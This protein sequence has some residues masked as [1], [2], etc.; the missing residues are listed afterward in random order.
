MQAAS[1][2]TL[3]RL[4][5][6]E[7]LARRF[8]EFAARMPQA[9]AVASQHRHMTYA[10]LNAHSN[11]LSLLL[12]EI[13]VAPE[14]R[15]AVLFDPSPEMAIAL[16]G[17]IKSGGAYVPLDPNW[18][19]SRI[20]A[21]LNDAAATALVTQTEFDGRCTAR[22]IPIL[23]VD[24]L[25]AT[26]MAEDRET[27]ET[28]ST[29]ANAAYVLYT[30]GSTGRPKAVVVEQRQVLTYLDAIVARLGLQPGMQYAM[31]QPLSVDACNTVLLPALFAGGTLHVFPHDIATEPEALLAYFTRHRID[32]MKIAPSH[33][34]ALLEACPRRELLPHLV[35]ALG[36]EASPWRWIDNVVQRLAPRTLRTF[37]HYGPTETTVGVLTHEVMTDSPRQGTHVP[38][39]RPV[40]NTA[41]Y[42]VDSGMKLAAVGVVGEVVVGGGSVARGYLGQPSMTA[43]RFVP[44]P[45]SSVPGA[46]VYRTGDL[47]RRLPTGDIEFVGR[48]DQQVKIR[49]FRIEL[50]EIVSV[51]QEHPVVERATVAAREY[52]AAGKCIIAYVIARRAARD[53]SMTQDRGE[54]A[55]Q[56][57][58]FVQERLPD[59]MVPSVV[60]VLDALPLT[61][62]G[63]VDLQALPPPE[64][65]RAPARTFVAPRTIAEA[66]L[67]D[68][69][70]T[71]LGIESI[72]IDDDFFS[73]G[74]HSLL[75]VRLIALV[76]RRL[77]HQLPIAA[78]FRHSTIAQLARILTEE[79]A[80]TTSPTFV[81]LRGG[82][83]AAVFCVHPIGGNVLCYRELARAVSSSRP[84]IGIQAASADVADAPRTIE[85]MARAY[86]AEI[87][88]AY[89]HWP[90]VLVAWSMGGLIAFEMARQLREGGVSLAA[91]VL[92]DS[93]PPGTSHAAVAET[94]V[95]LLA[96][97]A[98]DL[99][100]LA[101]KDAQPLREHFLAL[102]SAAQE[103]LLLKVLQDEG[104]LGA[105]SS[106]EELR[107]LFEV[108]ERNARA[109]EAYTL[110]AIDQPLVLIVA[111]SDS[112][113]LD[114]AWARWM[115]I[116]AVYRI[117]ADHYALL[118]APYVSAVA[119][120]ITCHLDS[121]ESRANAKRVQ[122]S[123]G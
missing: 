103:A 98:A 23:H 106:A 5:S 20:D 2:G 61:A 17:I 105:E 111:E 41:V 9:V 62:Q 69:W 38:L 57:R 72:G 12:R 89:G 10:E 118:Q 8:G 46:R 115:P 43:E 73:L 119:H 24:K 94:E 15:V 81:E 11:R 45:F 53:P 121:R 1:T 6:G 64:P 16:L 108:F 48:R 95:P 116:E 66:Q 82:S 123:H 97:F 70:Q 60:M 65:Q 29:Q 3:H 49:G 77:G 92:I 68:L 40:A 87:K 83:G 55:F 32:V 30:S 122:S 25:L 80:T 100:R 74:G 4:P 7:T 51:L 114:T 58:A 75:A 78:L 88:R 67:A 112:E 76:R 102:P 13:G 101:G 104:L 110:V 50:N 84:V 93:H 117:P 14:V 99:A 96:R 36:G 42:V 39:G 21:V 56:I 27:A 37:I 113:R 86:L 120:H 22:T 54:L 63:K 71:V 85:A 47:A 90:S 33:L 19:R 28:T 26:P 35:L 31:V 18:P 34:A 44:D 59:Y 79:R 107:P 109:A 52:G 91:L